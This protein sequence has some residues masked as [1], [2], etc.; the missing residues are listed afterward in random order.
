[1]SRIGQGKL[2][3][4]RLE[5]PSRFLIEERRYA[6]AYVVLGRSVHTHRPAECRR[7][8]HCSFVS[9]RSAVQVS[10]GWQLAERVVGGECNGL[11]SV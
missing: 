9:A 1:M 8:M 4:R 7:E 10:G 2:S 5:A 3:Y 11:V 6:P